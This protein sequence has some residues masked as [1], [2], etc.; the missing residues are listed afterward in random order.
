MLFSV[1][2]KQLVA[3]KLS[4][5]LTFSYRSKRD[6]KGCFWV[7]LLGALCG[8]HIS[9]ETPTEATKVNIS[10]FI[11]LRRNSSGL[12]WQFRR[13]S[14]LWGKKRLCPSPVWRSWPPVLVTRVRDPRSP[15]VPPRLRFYSNKPSGERRTKTLNIQ[16]H[17]FQRA[18]EP[19]VRRFL[20]CGDFGSGL[21]FFVSNDGF[22][23]AHTRNRHTQI[24]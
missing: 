6:F 22:F 19:S 8:L 13:N 12:S 24:F 10:T 3:E 5:P 4:H 7:F 15:P 2:T 16:E 11:S 18:I 20:D 14:I 9:P 1:P 21:F 17:Q 23:T